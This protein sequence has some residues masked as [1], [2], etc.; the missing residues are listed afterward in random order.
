MTE[1]SSGLEC[2]DQS[3][4]L[5]EG[6]SDVLGTVIEFAIND[7]FDMPDFLVGERFVF[8]WLL[9]LFNDTEFLTQACNL[10]T[11]KIGHTLFAPI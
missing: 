8:V 9:E 7:N 4:G 6:F 2:S 5:N 3:G 1:K 10:H 11:F